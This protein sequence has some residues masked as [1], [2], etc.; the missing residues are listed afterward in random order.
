M[1]LALR[2][3]DRARAHSLARFA[4]VGAIATAIDFA[5][6]SGLVLLAGVA[7][8]PANV[9]SYG[10]SLFANFNLN[11]R[12]TFRQQ[13]DAKTAARQGGRFVVAYGGGLLLSTAVVAGLSNLVP[14]LWAKIASVPVVFIYNYACAKFWV[15]REAGGSK[16]P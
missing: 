9:I 15:Y 7:A 14:E 5:V 12:W 10:T 4:I 8:A 2:L 3:I 16:N 11:R 1:K 13:R 6:F